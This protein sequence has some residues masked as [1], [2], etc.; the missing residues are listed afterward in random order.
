MKVSKRRAEH[1]G[2]GRMLIS[3]LLRGDV[4]GHR[5][6]QWHRHSTEGGQRR[7]V[8]GSD[9]RRKPGSAG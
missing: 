2:M 3:M 5:A 1:V 9:L 4:T 8:K 6:G 7:G